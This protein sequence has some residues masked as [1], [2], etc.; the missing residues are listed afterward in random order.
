MTTSTIQARVRDYS[1]ST[2]PPAGL[3]GSEPG[4]CVPPVGLW[5]ASFGTMK[6]DYDMHEI[7]EIKK[8][9]EAILAVFGASIIIG[10]VIAIL[11][12]RR[13]NRGN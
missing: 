2:V 7:I 1:K 13:L 9:G 6:W 12:N 4:L 8:Q 11:K 10:V 5:R 3:C